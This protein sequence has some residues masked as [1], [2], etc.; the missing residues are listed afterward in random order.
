MSGTVLDDQRPDLGGNIRHGD[1]NTF[2]PKLWNLLIDRFAI[3][4]MLDVGCGEGHT[5]RYFS[6]HGIFAHGIDGLI[7]NVRRAVIPIAHHDL[8]EA[9]YTMPVDLVWCCEVAEHI[10]E[11]K[12]HNLIDTLANGNIVAMTHAVP[13]QDGHHHVNLKDDNYWIDLME[14]RGYILDPSNQAFRELAREPHLHTFFAI[15]GLLFIRKN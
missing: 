4:S 13:G 15:S 8:L 5:V 12:V 1:I 10:S 14:A 2:H 11:D 3:R 9:P 7:S 6:R